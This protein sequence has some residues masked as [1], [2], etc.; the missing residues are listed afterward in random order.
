MNP[1][2]QGS[3][4]SLS[5]FSVADAA[6]SGPSG[7]RF[8]SVTAD[9]AR[10]VAMA[11]MVPAGDS[12]SDTRKLEAAKQAGLEIANSLANE[13]R[14]EPPP[15]APGQ[16]LMGVCIHWNCRGFGILRSTSCGE[17]F[18]HVKALQNCEDLVVGD[19]VTFEM[20]FD[21]RKQKPQA[22]NCI[23]AG[24]GA[25]SGKASG[26]QTGGVEDTFHGGAI[27]PSLGPPPRD[28]VSLPP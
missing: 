13:P 15:K 7:Q 12:E 11:N 1:S 25:L 22:L 19:V 2:M 16:S 3:S 6:D 14:T 21:H 8:P 28:E 10:S 4:P 23:K 27:Q 20:G 17:V 26:V 5:S 24:M 18:V 9:V